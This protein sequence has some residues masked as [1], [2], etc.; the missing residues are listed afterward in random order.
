LGRGCFN[1]CLSAKSIKSPFWNPNLKK[2]LEGVPNLCPFTEE[3]YR[4]MVILSFNVKYVLLSA[5]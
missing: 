4:K 2:K 1:P 5:I 3:K